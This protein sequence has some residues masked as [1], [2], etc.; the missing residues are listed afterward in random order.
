MLT[1]LLML[2]MV[3]FYDA[4][5]I[6][7]PSSAELT[8]THRACSLHPPKLSFTLKTKL[9][10][11]RCTLPT[12][13]TGLLQGHVIRDPRLQP[14]PERLIAQRLGHGTAEG[15]GTE[16]EKGRAAP[17]IPGAEGGSGPG[18]S[19][20]LDRPFTSADPDGSTARP[21]ATSS[22]TRRGECPAL[23]QPQHPH[24]RSP[25]AAAGRCPRRS[26]AAL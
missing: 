16:G 19:L 14:P 17:V 6:Q 26:P 10:R 4:G 20:Q 5:G 22:Q 11:S 9:E 7:T 18:R 8:P 2:S 13:C 12:G 3:C 1:T 15:E 24:S 21:G 25:A 23:G